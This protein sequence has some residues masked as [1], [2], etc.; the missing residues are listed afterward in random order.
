MKAFEMKSLVSVFQVSDLDCALSWY[1]K[2]LG[3]PDVISMEGVAEYALSENAWLQ[4][5]AEEKDRVG[6]SGIVIGVED[7]KNC[8]TILEQKGIE[9][10]EIID[11]EVVLVFDIQ[12]VDG[13]RITFAQEVE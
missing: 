10:G 13:N 12:D 5:S 6:S 7:V 2:W 11:Y 8:K 4:L 9:A 1:R 3:E